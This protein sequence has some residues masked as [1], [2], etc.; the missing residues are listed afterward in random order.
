MDD[1]ITKA[2]KTLRTE[3]RNERSSVNSEIK[4]FWDASICKQLSDIIAERD[5]KVVHTYLPMGSEV[6][7]LPLIQKI[8]DSGIEVFC[9][10]TLPNRVLENR[11]LVS[12]DEL[13]EGPMKTFHPK[14]VNVYEGHYDLII[15]PGLAFDNQNFRVGYGGGY[16]DGF[17]A[18]QNES[19]KAGVFYGFQEVASVPKESHDLSLDVIITPK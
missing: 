3:M 10:K 4:E 7:L 16:Y 14:E 2:K 18:N 11:V 15:V 9:P 1:E 8:L 13:E 6:N 5:I 17:L 12:L 19:L